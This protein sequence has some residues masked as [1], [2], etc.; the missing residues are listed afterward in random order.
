[1]YRVGFVGANE[2]WLVCC[3]GLCPLLIRLVGMCMPAS[4]AAYL[5]VPQ[6]VAVFCGCTG[7]YCTKPRGGRPVGW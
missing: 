4:G 2:V 5:S 7:L 1:M 6:H 3:V